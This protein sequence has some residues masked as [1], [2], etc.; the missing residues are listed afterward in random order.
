LIYLRNIILINKKDSYLQCI[1]LS[2]VATP[3]P[4]LNNQHGLVRL[5]V[6]QVAIGVGAGALIGGAVGVVAGL[7]GAYLVG[8]V[9][10]VFGKLTTDLVAY[11]MYGTPIGTWEDYAVAFAFGGFT[12]GL[13]GKGLSWGGF[14]LDVAVRPLFNQLAKIGT[15]RQSEMNW[16]KYGYDVATR[17]LTYAVPSPWRSFARGITRGHWSVYGWGLSGGQNATQFYYA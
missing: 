3:Y 12:R 6:G 7:G 15:G 10:S 5:V 13:F 1:E 9:S 4:V 8:G 16:S 11:S 17:A 2:I 14:G